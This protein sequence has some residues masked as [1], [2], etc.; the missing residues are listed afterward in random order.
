[1]LGDVFIIMKQPFFTEEFY[2]NPFTALSAMNDLVK[3]NLVADKE[4]YQSGKFLFMEVY[5][6]EKSREILLSS[7]SDF[8]KYKS[9]NNE[10]YPSDID[11]EIGLCALHDLHNEYFPYEYEILWDS[12]N[13]IFEFRGTIENDDE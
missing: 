7:I 9:F 4:M 2:N 1:M 10:K 13:E 3:Q 6:N 11:T 12:E 8:E 5:D